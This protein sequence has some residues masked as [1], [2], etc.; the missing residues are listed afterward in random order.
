MQPSRNFTPDGE[1]RY[2]ADGERVVRCLT[3]GLQFR[4]ASIASHR[5]AHLRRG[6]DVT[7]KA[8]GCKPLTVT[9]Q[10]YDRRRAWILAERDFMARGDG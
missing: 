10:E 4:K 6:Q 7:T 1:Y 3:C 8:W 9:V 2:A 5:R